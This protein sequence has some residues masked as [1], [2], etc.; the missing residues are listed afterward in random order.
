MSERI[1]KEIWL[2][3]VGERIREKR[4]ALGREF[5]SREFFVT[6]RSENLFQY[7]DWISTRYLASIELGN[8]QMSIEKL[9]QIAYA[10]EIEPSDLFAE[11]VKI[12]QENTSSRE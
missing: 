10:L 12:Y 2:K 6:D 11:V 3:H 1:Q 9:I 8:N 4:Y 7:E 5:Q